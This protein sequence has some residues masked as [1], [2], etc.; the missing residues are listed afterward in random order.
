M[1]T[2]RFKISSLLQIS[3]VMILTSLSSCIS[4]QRSEVIDDGY[5]SVSK[6][7]K[8]NDHERD[9]SLSFTKKQKIYIEDYGDSLLLYPSSD[10]ISIPRTYTTTANP[11]LKIVLILICL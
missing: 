7:V 10:K 5:Y 11:S 1:I 3:I 2:E 8:I 9:S 6:A 4:V